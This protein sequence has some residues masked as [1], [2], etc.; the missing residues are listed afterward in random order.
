MT[1]RAFYVCPNKESRLLN[2][3]LFQDAEKQIWNSWTPAAL[4]TKVSNALSVDKRDTPSTWLR[5]RRPKTSLQDKVLQSKLELLEIMKKNAEIE[6]KI[7]EEQLKQEKINT[8]KLEA[9]SQ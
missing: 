2:S 9:E 4:K 1:N 7:K 3:L 8:A 5:R 6:G